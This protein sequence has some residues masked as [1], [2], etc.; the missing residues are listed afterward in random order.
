MTDDVVAR[1]D[2]GKLFHARGAAT[3]NARSPMVDCRTSGTRINSRGQ[4]ARNV[5]WVSSTPDVWQRTNSIVIMLIC[6][7]MEIIKS[8]YTKQNS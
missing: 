7:N 5:H 3:R 2:D 8:S 1:T 6:S 4:R